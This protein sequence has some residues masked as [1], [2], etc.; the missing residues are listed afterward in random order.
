[1][2]VKGAPDLPWEAFAAW[3]HPS[4]VGSRGNRVDDDS[5]GLGRAEGCGTADGKEKIGMVWL[6]HWPL[7]DLIEILDK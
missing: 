7:C 3:P 1:M 6:T 5:V 2:L 4:P